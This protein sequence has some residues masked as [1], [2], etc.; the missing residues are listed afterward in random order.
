MVQASGP[1]RIIDEWRCL[2]LARQGDETSWRF[3]FHRHYQ[4]LVRMTFCITG[5]LDAAKD[6]AQ[7]SFV[8]LLRVKIRH[9]EGSFSAYLSTIAYRLAL[10]ERNRRFSAC[11]SEAGDFADGELSP[12][13][14]VIR[15]ETQR[16]IFSVM[17]SLSIDHR[18][19]L[20]LRFFGGHSYEEIARIT[21]VPIGTVKS[22]I[23]CAI[24]TCRER[25]QNKGVF[26]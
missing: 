10:K 21:N 17:Q 26:A 6:L 3:L 15:D 4:P 13:E 8:R 20:A 2:D 11:D 16:V 24:K 19:I 22:R 1:G 18:E 14:Q 9:H 12:L 5:S 25:L 23:F 7:E